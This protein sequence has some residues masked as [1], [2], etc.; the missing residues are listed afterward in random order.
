MKTS[1]EDPLFGK[2]S[3]ERVLVWLLGGISVYF[4]IRLNALRFI[5]P[6]E[7]LLLSAL[8]ASL[9]VF[10]VFLFAWFV[11]LPRFWQPRKLRGFVLVGLLFALLMIPVQGVIII[12]YT[13]IPSYL[14]DPRTVRYFWGVAFV[15]TPGIML[16]LWGLWAGL[17]QRI[18]RRQL[19]ELKLQKAQAELLLLKTQMQPHF[20][21]NTLNN[22]YALSFYAPERLPD[23]LLKLSEIMQYVLYDCLHDHVPLAKERQYLTNF[24]DLYRI[25]AEHTP[26]ITVQWEVER[27]DVELPPMLLQPLIENAL[28]HSHVL[29]RPQAWATIQIHV[30]ATGVEVTIRNSFLEPLSSKPAELASTPGMGL[31]NVRQRLEILTKG[32]YTLRASTEGETFHTYLYFPLRTT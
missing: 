19:T 10:S 21:L 25:K 32:A 1:A 15:G 22:L 17:E 12:K 9:F 7:K 29:T 8:L 4:L 11:W 5:T 28:K 24:I 18:V 20:L 3:R 30:R 6:P 16:M 23:L 26:A 2:L 31:A 14:S 13:A 27:P